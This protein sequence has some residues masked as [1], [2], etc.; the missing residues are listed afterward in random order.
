M[1][2]WMSTVRAAGRLV[3]PHETKVRF[4]AAGAINTGFGL[5]IFPILMWS[6]GPRGVHYLIVLLISQILSVTVAFVTN[7]YFVFRTAGNHLAE[8]GRFSI[9]YISYFLVNIV[10]LP[11]LVEVVHFNPIVAQT[12]FS[13]SVIL[14]SY[15][16]HKNITFRQKKPSPRSE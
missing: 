13:L 2:A 5:A 3:G 6:L 11:M 16:W 8:Y 7:K 10:V 4:L 15:I 12:M 14:L 9:F 1:E